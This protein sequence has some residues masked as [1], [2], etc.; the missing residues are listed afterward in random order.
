MFTRAFLLSLA[1]HAAVVGGVLAVSGGIRSGR[2]LPVIMVSL[3]GEGKAAGSGKSTVLRSVQPV[4]SSPSQTDSEQPVV[5]TPSRADHA[6]QELMA[7]LTAPSQSPWAAGIA[8]EA[9]VGTL[10]G[11]DAGGSPGGISSDLW[12]HL[13]SAIEGAKTYP[14]LARERGIEGTVLV[15]F[16]VL[17]TGDIETVHVVK[18]SGVQI[19]DEA[20]VRTVYRAAPMPFVNGWIEV[21][22]VYE[23]K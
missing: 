19:L 18:S 3:V 8:G 20:S 12:Q 5:A 4:L 14:R 23:L 16:K 7:D 2:T 11:T 21:P 6:E 15:R 17:P 1:I 9:G 10:A 22:M 13:H